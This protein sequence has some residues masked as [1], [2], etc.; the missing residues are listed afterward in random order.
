MINQLP[1]HFGQTVKSAVRTQFA[2]LCYRIKENKVQILMVTTRRSGRWIIPKGWPV[3]GMEP[4]NSAAREAW[5]EAGV[6]GRPEMRPLGLFSY[7]K[8]VS[9][10]KSLSC[11]AVVYAVK[12]NSLAETFPEQGQ[13]ERKWVSSKKAASMVVEPDLAQI[14]LDYNPLL[15]D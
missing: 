12:V 9:K 8:F 2:A 4:Q 3:N 15:V 11:V 1:L 7:S 13:R 14:L 6:I 10:K 5:E